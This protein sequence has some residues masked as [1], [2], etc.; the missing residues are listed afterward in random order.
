MKSSI[1]ALDVV[2]LLTESHIPMA[3]A[4]AEEEK[5]HEIELTKLRLSH[6]VCLKVVVVRSHVLVSTAGHPATTAVYRPLA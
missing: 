1:P 2:V 5:C 3:E 4:K 6:G